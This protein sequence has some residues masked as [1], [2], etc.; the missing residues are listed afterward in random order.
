M[1]PPAKRFSKSVV[2]VLDA[3]KYLG[4]RSGPDHRFIAV[5]PV[6]L[7]GRL[8]IRSWNDKPTGWYRAFLA[9]PRG[10][11]QLPSGREIKVRARPVRARRVIEAMETAYAEKY[12]TPGSRHYVVGFKRARR[13]ATTV[14]LVP[15]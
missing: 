10:S 13:R 2:G 15:R 7:T 11:I 12:P 3:T 14:E 4:I 6:V 8:F 1:S 9:E 5:W